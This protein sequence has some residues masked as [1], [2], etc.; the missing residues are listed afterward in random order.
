VSVGLDPRG[1]G[2]LELTTQDIGFC[3]LSLFEGIGLCT[4][5]CSGLVVSKSSSKASVLVG[6]K[7]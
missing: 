5:S 1:I 7:I 2:G 4:L 6:E 3:G